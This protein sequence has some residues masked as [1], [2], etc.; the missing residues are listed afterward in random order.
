MIRTVRRLWESRLARLDKEEQA[1]EDFN[2]ILMADFHEENFMDTAQRRYE[3]IL[4]E[5]PD[6]DSSVAAKLAHEYAVQVV[7]P[8]EAPALRLYYDTK[9]Q[10]VAQGICMGMSRKQAHEHMVALLPLTI[11]VPYVKGK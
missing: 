2:V 10:L 1:R 8:N 4:R 6:V 9:R 7:K 3:A 5:T 11:G